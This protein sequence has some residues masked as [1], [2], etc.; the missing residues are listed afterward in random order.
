MLLR[1]Q[2]GTSPALCFPVRY[3]QIKGRTRLRATICR[4]L[5]EPA[6]NRRL[7]ETSLWVAVFARRKGAI[8]GTL[9][10]IR[11]EQVCCEPLDRRADR[12]GKHCGPADGIRR[13]IGQANGRRD[14]YALPDGQRSFAA[15]SKLCSRFYDARRFPPRNAHDPVTL[16]AARMADIAR[17]AGKRAIHENRRRYPASGIRDGRSDQPGM[18]VRPVAVITSPHATPLSFVPRSI[19]CAGPQTRRRRWPA[20]AHN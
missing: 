18:P 3:R 14:P 10:Y 20:S 7:V 15:D 12:S 1:I 6:W 9:A 16:G 4:A 19:S 17:G 8:L 11:P 5:D 13:H 2:S